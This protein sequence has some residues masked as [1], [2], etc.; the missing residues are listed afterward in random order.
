M[1]DF[2]ETHNLLPDNLNS[3]TEIVL[4]PMNESLNLEAQKIAKQIRDTGR[5]VSVDAG[6]KRVGEKI[7]RADDAGAASV[8]VIGEDEVKS[9]TFTLKDLKSGEEKT[10]SVSEI[11]V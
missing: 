11:L 6:K 5:S 8:I 3:V 1:K 10:G 7:G 4:I 9:Q 2:L